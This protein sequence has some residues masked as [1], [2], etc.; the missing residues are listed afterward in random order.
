MRCSQ[1]QQPPTVAW[2][3]AQDFPWIVVD[4][5][6]GACYVRDVRLGA[7]LRPGGCAAVGR[8]MALGANEARG[9]YAAMVM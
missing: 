4:A 1:G 5:D 6:A 7:S 8:I 2:K 3:C 9:L